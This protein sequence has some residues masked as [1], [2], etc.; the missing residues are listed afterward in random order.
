ML[1][2][3][4]TKMEYLAIFNTLLFLQTPTLEKFLIISVFWLLY[5]RSKIKCKSIVKMKR[6]DSCEVVA[7]VS[8]KLLKG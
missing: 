6:A 3:L 4:D 8:K 1:N 5:D 2:I 7:A